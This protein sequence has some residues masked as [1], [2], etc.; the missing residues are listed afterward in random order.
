MQD[1]LLDTDASPRSLAELM[2]TADSGVIALTGAPAA[3]EEWV[4]A[5]AEHACD[6]A[7][8][9][10]DEFRYLSPAS[11]R[12]TVA[13]LAGS[14]VAQA[15]IQPLGP[16]WV[17]AVADAASMDPAAAARLLKTLE[18]PPS[19]AWYVLCRDDEDLLPTA[20]QGRVTAEFTV[21][22]G[23]DPLTDA[24][25][26][27]GASEHL[28]QLTVLPRPGRNVLAT[29][30]R[31]GREV[32]DLAGQLRPRPVGPWT[33]RIARATLDR[34]GADTRSALAGGADPVA[35]D[36]AAREIA[37]ARTR[38]DRYVPVEAAIAPVIDALG[39]LGRRGQEP[40]SDTRSST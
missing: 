13:E 17:I 29:A 6:H 19:P 10:A 15:G 16:G 4:R 37:D 8:L 12:W 28:A 26:A 25:R 39:S 38:V 18:E 40:W 30:T 9:R 35:C 21:G 34:A 36:R 33:R 7:G 22:T 27:A 14:V 31:W 5:A 3:C 1:P 20:L 24:A 23:G 32:R 11:D 2:S